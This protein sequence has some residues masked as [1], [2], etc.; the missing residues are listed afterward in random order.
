ME[1][2]TERVNKAPLH[3][4]NKAKG[5]RWRDE[6]RQTLQ[7]PTSKRRLRAAFAARRVAAD[8]AVA[9]CKAGG[10]FPS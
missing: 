8:K 10:G 6:S 7:E 4:M 2:R 1:A 9:A 5:Q 3:L